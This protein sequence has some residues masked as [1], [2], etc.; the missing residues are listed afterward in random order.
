MCHALRARA[1]DLIAEV[2]TTAFALPV[3]VRRTSVLRALHAPQ[4]H[5]RRLPA[6]VCAVRVQQIQV[7]AEAHLLERALPASARRMEVLRAAPAPPESLSRRLQTIVH[8]SLV[9]LTQLVVAVRLL[10]R[11]VLA[12][13]ATG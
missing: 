8:A 7:A 13:P 6:T 1:P 2:R 10:V 11:E 5:T 12:V 4:A 3:W 9:H